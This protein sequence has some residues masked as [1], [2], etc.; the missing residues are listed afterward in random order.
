M[1]DHGADG[2]RVHA[3][4]TAG[5]TVGGLPHAVFASLILPGNFL[6]L[7]PFGFVCGKGFNFLDLGG[8]G[9]VVGC[10]V[11]AGGGEGA[12]RQLAIPCND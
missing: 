12:G 5:F 2:D 1:T 4:C 7:D 8:L 11:V 6:E 10:K 9:H 3:C